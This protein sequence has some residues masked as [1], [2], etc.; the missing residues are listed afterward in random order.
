M[1]KFCI[2]S[3]VAFLTMPLLGTAANAESF[4]NDLGEALALFAVTAI[5]YLAFFITLVTL[6]V[7]K[8]K[9]A[10]LA[11]AGI[12]LTI[13]VVLPMID[14]ALMSWQNT[15]VAKAQISKPASDLRRK[16]LLYLSTTDRCNY[17]ICEALMHLRGGAPMWVIAP[18]NLGKLNLKTA[19]DLSKVPLSQ[20]VL[21]PDG[22][23]SFMIKEPP[24]GEARPFF[25]YVI[26]DQSPYYLSRTGLI[27]NALHLM[28]TSF[29]LGDYL[30]LETLAAP[31]LNNHLDLGHITPDYLTFYNARKAYKAPLFPEN[32]VTGSWR[33]YDEN[34]DR[35]DWFCGSGERT[36]EQYDCARALR[37]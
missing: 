34:R 23:N 16:T 19:I 14:T 32:T 27:E 4:G 37:R 24:K 29:A 18:E 35:Q 13:I 20:M 5:A 21:N 2:T 7:L 22:H 26:I 3:G 36:A 25:D 6:A 15:R 30:V 8:Q 31:I 28:P 10:L 33:N 9:R 17:Q 1:H 11:V 12:G